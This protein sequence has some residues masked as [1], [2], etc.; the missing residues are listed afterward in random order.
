MIV[1]IILIELLLL[2]VLSRRL[3]QNLFVAVF[4]LTKS[5]PVAVSFLSILFFPGTVI[6]ELAHLFTAEILGVRTSG[7]T[8]VPEGID[9]KEVRTGSVSIAQSDPIRRAMIGIA[10][11][12][13]GLLTL[14]TLSYFFSQQLTALYLSDS[15]I[16]GMDKIIGISIAALFYL[17]FAVSNTM[18]SSPEDLEGFWPV[19]VV[20]TLLAGAAYIAGLRIT[21]TEPVLGGVIEFFRSVAVNLGYV[22]GLNVA[23]FFFS[24]LLIVGVTKVTRVM[25]RNK[26]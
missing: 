23:L 9:Q 21:L 25:V 5:R 10:P 11:V 17:I 12:F 6:H 2:Y 19:V 18:F 8:L 13:V 4:L 15:P 3:T 14:G 26:T 1:I 7:M 22:T 24:Q 20:L 16:G